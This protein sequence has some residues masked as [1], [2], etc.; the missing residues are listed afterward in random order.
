[1][2]HKEKLK[3]SVGNT[4]VLTLSAT[5][6]PRTLQ[7]SL[8]GLRD[9]SLMN[10]PPEGRV[11][12]STGV[13]RYN[14]TVVCRAIE[15]E[16][17]RGGQVFV[18]CPRIAQ[19]EKEIRTLQRLMPEVRFVAAHGKLPNLLGIIEAFGERQ[20]D[21][22]VATTV[23]ENGIDMPNVNTIIVNYSEMFGMGQLYQLRG[24]VGRSNRQAYAYFLTRNDSAITPEAEERLEHLRV[25][26]APGSGYDLSR[27]DME[28][29]GFGTLFGT[30]QS[31]AKEVGMDLQSDIL[32]RQVEQLKRELVLPSAETRIALTT[33]LEKDGEALVG[34]PMPPPH[35]LMAVSRWEAA[36]AKAILE[37]WKGDKAFQ[38]LGPLLSASSTSVLQE[39]TKKWRGDHEGRLPV[40]VAELLVRAHA[41]IMCRRA[42]ITQVSPAPPD[43][44]LGT[45]VGAL[46]CTMPN[47]TA[48]K[49]AEIL[50]AAV[51]SDMR[52]SFAERSGD[53]FLYVAT[54]SSSSSSNL[55]T[56]PTELL[57]LVKPLVTAVEEKMLTMDG[58][59]PLPSV[60]SV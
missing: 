60:P 20:F 21:V 22:L 26:N 25:F 43:C 45:E 9:L 16:M 12:V 6:I 23:I 11:A 35:D 58:L 44:P 4:D 47:V 41:R 15:R 39:L 32:A 29:R 40:L 55:K 56:I 46:E 2:D 19:V 3:A 50:Q 49:W 34:E 31:G 14:E 52:V 42:G 13:F 59:A 48:Y 27:K 28:M 18:V 17:E 54:T 36:V 38:Y 57:K 24:R 1:M 33:R 8:A 7:L 30:E 53:G 51:P 5:P 37:K 10:S